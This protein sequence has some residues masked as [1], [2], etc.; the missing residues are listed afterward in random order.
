MRCELMHKDVTVAVVCMIDALCEMYR[1]DEVMDE[2]HM[3][4]GTVVDGEV[5]ADNLFDWWRERHIPP[6][7]HGLRD[8]MD[9]L[10]MSGMGASWEVLFKSMGLSLSD[11]YWIRP[12]GSDIEW[13]DVNFFDN[14]FSM[15]E[16]DL[17]FGHGSVEGADL[18]SPD[19]FTNGVLRKR[20]TVVDGKRCLVKGCTPLRQEPY[21]ED[22]ASDLMR[23]QGI[24]HVDYSVIEVYGKPCSICEGFIDRSTEL[25]PASMVLRSKPRDDRTSAYSHYVS[26]CEDLGLD[27]VPDLD[28]MM[29][30]DYLMLNGD[31]HFGNFGLIRN[32]DTLEWIGTA[33]IYDTGSSLTYDVPSFRF[34]TWQGRASKPFARS[35]DNQLKLVTDMSWFDVQKMEETIAYAE[36]LIR[37]ED[38][39]AAEG[40]DKLLMGLMSD[41][42]QR[43]V[44]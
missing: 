44:G 23:R 30:V 35:F 19:L 32:A 27:V 3:P 22:I 25:V 29:A 34:D 36:G 31:R 2:D 20:W 5:Q 13:R 9:V 7:R 28:R 8:F 21:N 1:V 41:R 42:L 17:L 24:P 38:A 14:G 37:R 15:D 33:P 40:R 26:C 43:L 39:L 6:A 12:A 16:G 18:C 11:Q 10:S 4:F